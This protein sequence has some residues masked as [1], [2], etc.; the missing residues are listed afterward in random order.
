M[1]LYAM[2]ELDAVAATYLKFKQ[3][4]SG[5]FREGKIVQNNVSCVARQRI[6]VHPR[7]HEAPKRGDILYFRSDTRA[8][9]ILSHTLFLV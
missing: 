7:V 8:P 3:F 4:N 9:K 6:I 2:W 1:T 5:G